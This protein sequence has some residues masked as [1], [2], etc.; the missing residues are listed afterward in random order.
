M[1]GPSADDRDR[2]IHVLDGLRRQAAVLADLVADTEERVA[3]TYEEMARTRPPP[4][5]ERLRGHAAR[6]R[7]FAARERDQSARYWRGGGDG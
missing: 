6:A 5:A 3:A 4:D 1:P 2:I 7:R